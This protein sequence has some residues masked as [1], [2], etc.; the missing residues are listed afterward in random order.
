MISISTIR[1][2]ILLKNDA[3][4]FFILLWCRN[5]TELLHQSKSI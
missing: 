4:V 1:L 5:N 3:Q 2:L